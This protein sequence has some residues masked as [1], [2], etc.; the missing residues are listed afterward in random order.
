MFVPILPNKSLEFWV[1]YLLLGLITKAEEP[2][3][4]LLLLLVGR[5]SGDRILRLLLLLLRMRRDTRTEK[6]VMLGLLQRLVS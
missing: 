1:L 4:P 5:V 2:I 6:W 3:P